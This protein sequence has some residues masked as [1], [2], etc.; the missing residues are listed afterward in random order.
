MGLWIFPV[1]LT[2]LGTVFF[3]LIAFVFVFQRKVDKQTGPMLVHTLL[4]L[5]DSL[6]DALFLV[7]SPFANPPLMYAAVFFFWLVFIPPLLPWVEGL[8]SALLPKGKRQS[9]LLFFNRHNTLE[10]ILLEVVGVPLRVI[11]SFFTYLSLI[12]C[13]GLSIPVVRRKFEKMQGFRIPRHKATQLLCGLVKVP[14]LEDDEGREKENSQVDP[15]TGAVQASDTRTWNE[16][17]F[18]QLVFY[19][20]IMESMPQ[21]IVQTVNVALLQQVSPAFIASASMS[22][23]MIVRTLFGFG[24]RTWELRGGDV[25]PES[26]EPGVEV[27][28]KVDPEFSQGQ[29]PEIGRQ[30]SGYESVQLAVALP[31]S[32][33]ESEFKFDARTSG[34]RTALVPQDPRQTESSTSLASVSQVQAA[35]GPVHPQP[36]PDTTV[37]NAIPPDGV[38]VEDFANAR[39]VVSLPAAVPSHLRARASVARMRAG[40]LGAG[41]G[42]DTT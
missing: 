14:E 29:R 28:P 35:Y 3:L 2:S 22:A 25:D 11:F 31:V 17:T 15:S 1:G 12:Q 23:Y 9:P 37:S 18:L 5:G 36:Q 39:R 19:E 16:T 7:L 6:T 42:D 34:S 26:A 32:K 33:R 10:R 21:V 30:A 38:H 27:R 8:V 4:S 24:Y 20:A 40:D 13:K 41:G